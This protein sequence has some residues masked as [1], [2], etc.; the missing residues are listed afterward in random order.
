MLKLQI[1]LTAADRASRVIDTFF[2]NTSKR[3]TALNE[4]QRRMGDAMNE[5]ASGF[6]AAGTTI[7][8][9]LGIAASE[10]IKF[11]DAMAGVGKVMGMKTG[12]Q[13]LARVGQEVQDIAKYMGTLPT[14]AAELYANLAQGGAAKDE[15]SEIARNAGRVAVAFDIDPGAAGERFIKLRN[16][17]ALTTDQTKLATDAINHLS[18]NTAAKASQILDFFASGAGGASR[19][20]ELNAA[21]AAA[22]GSVYISM[23]KSGEEAATIF[24]RMT[25]T[26][27]NTDKAAGAVYAQAGGGMSGLMAALEKGMRLEDSARFEYFKEFGEYG[28]EVEQL[29]NNMAMLQKHIGLVANEQT[30]AGSVHRE[31]ANRTSTTAFKLRQAQANAQILAIE[32]G[33]H[34][35]PVITSTI[36]AVVPFAQKIIDWT[37]ANP[38][39]TA[40]IVSMAGAIGSALIVISAATKAVAL[41]NF[42]LAAN[43]IVLVIAAVAALAASVYLIYKNWG[44]ISGWFSEKWDAI[45]G[46]IIAMKDW[47]LSTAKE[48][49]TAGVE[50]TKAIANGIWEGLTW[51]MEAMYNLGKKMREYLPFSPAKV[52]PLRDLPRVKIAETIAGAIS[53]APVQA[54]MR[55]AVMPIA[56]PFSGP[57]AVSGQSPAANSSSS[58]IAINFSPTI[59]AGA[60]SG[61][62]LGQLRQYEGELR[63]MI[64]EVMR[65][66][67]REKY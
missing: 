18:D 5:A 16:T 21:Q 53:P 56:A 19:A 14:Q 43:P 4:Q 62:V 59:N 27:R 66:D 45:K 12:S 11:E 13:E 2:G 38:A 41:F 49:F 55:A 10:A 33:T 35:L 17:L 31:F 51:P 32:I 40:T 28:I 36:Q 64:Q 57:G 50:V 9:P 58:G 63:R 67:Q 29:A 42:V 44:P 23:G 25:K 47:L 60:G 7:L 39:A 61:D 46:G 24:E 52:G 8:A 15:L 54:A 6:A 22:V 20:L 48:F 1:M 30:Y 34:L 26:L 37:R 3:F 65:R